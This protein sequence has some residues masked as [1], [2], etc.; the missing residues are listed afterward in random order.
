MQD[1]G[2]KSLI[3][4][5]LA[6]AAISL[7]LI[8]C[9]ARLAHVPV[10]QSPQVIWS[11]WGAGPLRPA[12]DWGSA[13]HRSA[14]SAVEGIRWENARCA[15]FIS[16]SEAFVV[17]QTALVR[18]GRQSGMPIY[19]FDS[20]KMFS[21]GIASLLGL[22]HATKGYSANMQNFAVEGAILVPEAF[23]FPRHLRGSKPPG[24]MALT[25]DRKI[26][27][28]AARD[29]GGKSYVALWNLL[30]NGRMRLL[31]TGLGLAAGAMAF[32]PSGR[33]LAVGYNPIPAAGPVCI[34][35]NVRTGKPTVTLS[36]QET[37]PGYLPSGVAY[38]Q[39]HR[40]A[41][42]GGGKLLL[43]DLK[44]KGHLHL[45]PK[46]ENVVFAGALL[47]SPSR[48][49][50]MVALGTIG[51]QPDIA[52]YSG[53]TGHIIR[54]ISIRFAYASLWHVTQ[55]AAGGHPHDVIAAL[56]SKVAGGIGFFC[57]M[58]LATGRMI[59]RSPD[60]IGGCTSVTVSP[61]GRAA[62]T[63]GPLGADLWRLPKDAQ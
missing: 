47:A 51:G 42:T 20:A 37:W 29:R 50:F 7:G 41:I 57:D 55:L 10:A 12:A 38:L 36:R 43:A 4:R 59:W 32:S 21:Q 63:G 26:L 13:V 48:Q 14:L 3:M 61:D 17:L 23:P 40:L 27:A 34:V 19:R 16:P 8:G 35:W 6:V 56:S 44:G 28:T 46:P 1:F 11:W 54:R 15:G 62:I 60:I 5:M 58:D 24:G 31:S 9:R 53:R 33:H 30:K 25:A 49:N 2:R 22:R 52:I 18:I 45:V 39:N